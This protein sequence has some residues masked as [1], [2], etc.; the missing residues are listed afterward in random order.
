MSL[1]HRAPILSLGFLAILISITASAQTLTGCEKTRT[2]SVHMSALDQPFFLNR[3]GAL[4]PE[5]QVYALDR[6][7]EAKKCPSG[8]SGCKPTKGNAQLRASKRPR[9]I[10]L[11]ANKGD[12]LAIHF[13]NLLADAPANQPGIEGVQ[14][15]TRQASVHVAGMQVVR[16]IR[17]DGSYV[18]VNGRSTVPPGSSITYL[19]R[20]T[21][22]GTFLLN[23][24]GAA[25]GGLDQPNDGAQVTAGLFG[26][27][28]VEPAGSGCAARSSTTSCCRRS[29]TPRA[30][31]DSARS[32]SRSSTSTPRS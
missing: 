30:T 10:V 13:T 32:G 28:N 14:S 8:Q 23:S 19:L 12:C 15:T 16:T 18:G 4:M 31:T 1:K 7:I 22:E 2:I 21:E 17:D 20:A 25:W 5:G 27:V 6:D 3:L 26:A 29:I 11:R 24:E 9:P